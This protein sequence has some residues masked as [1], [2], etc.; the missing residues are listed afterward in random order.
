M[1]GREQTLASRKRHGVG[2]RL[3]VAE[4]LDGCRLG[5][6]RAQVGRGEVARERRAFP[7]SVRGRASGSWAGG[8][9][10]SL[11]KSQ[12]RAMSNGGLLGGRTPP[13]VFC[14]YHAPG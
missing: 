10:L 3:R 11:P 1:A 2:W 13:E 7:K 4:S 9:R 14:R 12:R 6:Y 8:K 5:H